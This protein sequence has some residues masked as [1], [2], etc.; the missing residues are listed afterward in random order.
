MHDTPSEEERPRFSPN[1]QRIIFTS[2][3]TDP[4]QIWMCGLDPAAGRLIGTPQQVTKL[5][6]GADGA[7]WSA[8]GKNLLLV[9]SVYPD[10]KD[11]ACNQQRDEAL[12]KSKVKSEDF[13]EFTLSALD[14][15]HG[16][17]A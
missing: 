11:D 5:S 6:T 17:Q 14:R 3:A 9:S 13:Q 16:V 1:G 7:I 2:K 15:L 12:K 10:C 8:D 4:S